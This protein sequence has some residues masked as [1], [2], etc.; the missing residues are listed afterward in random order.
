MI[1]RYCHTPISV[2]TDSGNYRR[3]TGWVKLRQKGANEVALCEDL[4]EYACR[5][6]M[7]R[8]KSGVPVGQETLL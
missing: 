3:V 4:F 6:C 5:V 7:S 8:L 2:N 1:C